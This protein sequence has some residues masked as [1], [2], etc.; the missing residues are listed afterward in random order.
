[1]RSI[2]IGEEV[3]F[4]Y[5]MV[6][7]E[8]VSSDIVFEMDCRCKTQRCRKIITENDWK[9]KMLQQKYKGF[10]SQYLQEKIAALQRSRR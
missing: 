6:V 9:L 8:S 3:T 2:R 10:F 5:G 4:D 1:M 7:S